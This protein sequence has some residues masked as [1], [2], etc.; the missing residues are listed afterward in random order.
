MHSDLKYM[1]YSGHDDNVIAFMIAYNLL[2]TDCVWNKY[3]ALPKIKKDG[4][5]NAPGFA[6]SFLWELSQNAVDQKFYVRSLFNGKAVEFCG[7]ASTGDHYCEFSD[8]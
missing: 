1:M 2:N 4:C 7:G 3:L 5:A 8:F 6:S